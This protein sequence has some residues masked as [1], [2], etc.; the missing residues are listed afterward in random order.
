MRE[1]SDYFERALLV[2]ERAKFA[3]VEQQSALV[4]LAKSWRELASFATTS[5]GGHSDVDKTSLLQLHPR[6]YRAL[7]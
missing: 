1:I 5:I 6:P 7:P 2:E 4:E 3:P